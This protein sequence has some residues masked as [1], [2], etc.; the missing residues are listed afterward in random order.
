[1]LKPYT[2]K[3]GMGF[4]RRSHS[5]PVFEDEIVWDPIAS[6]N[7]NIDEDRD[8]SETIS[9]NEIDDDSKVRL[10]HV[11]RAVN[12][13]TTTS[14][15]KDHPLTPI[16]VSILQQWAEIADCSSPEQNQ[17]EMM[18]I[19]NK[20]NL[21]HE[22]EESIVALG[23]FKTWLDQQQHQ[24]HNGNF[25]IN[26]VDLCCGKGI[27]SMLASYVFQ[28][29]P[30]VSKIIMLDNNSEL[31]WSH[32]SI[33]NRHAIQDHR[34]LIETHQGNLFEMDDVIQLLSNNNDY[35][36]D[37]FETDENEISPLAFIGIHL[38]KNLSPTFVGIANALG[39]K[40]VPFLCLA[41]CCLP[42]VVLGGRKNQSGD[43]TKTRK[44]LLEVAQYESPFQR[45]A[46]LVAAKRR[47][48]AKQR[49][50]PCLLCQS[51]DHRLHQCSHFS[52]MGPSEQQ[53]L[54]KRAAEL[55][56]CWKC[57]EIGHVK[58]ECPSNQT[59]SLPPLIPRA[60]TRLDVSPITKILTTNN[61]KSDDIDPFESYC[62]LLSKAIERDE[63]HLFESGL[64]NTH[65][66]SRQ[67][68]SNWN[69]GRKS[70]FI[71][72]TTKNR[73]HLQSLNDSTV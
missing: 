51:T 62:N 52:L 48:Q 56:P 40:K 71:V 20:N 2:L 58:S 35:D 54:L 60:V 16:V 64:E 6:Y 68:E 1:M 15:L 7:Y 18:G 46:R 5:S 50:S 23:F 8:L 4:S 26:L 70:I 55:E 34:P 22:V 63:K 53:K 66:K 21:L 59:S 9:S 61:I 25:S 57:G 12:K 33:V 27:C 32:V 29:D 38:C 13:L 37:A 14:T 42:R 36:N 43:G 11:W 10:L 67:H 30:R 72:A 24:R 3:G 19:L 45:Q 31:D 28:G 65:A 47:R 17:P 41:P 44:R 73:Q 39:S 69:R 49:R